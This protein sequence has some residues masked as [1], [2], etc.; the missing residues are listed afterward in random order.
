M[1]NKQ[2]NNHIMRI[3]FYLLFILIFSTSLK[4]QAGLRNT[5]HGLLVTNGPDVMITINEQY[6]HAEY[7]NATISS[8]TDGSIFQLRY[9]AFLDE[10]E[11]ENAGKRY[12]LNKIE[13]EEI[14]FT[15][16]NKKYV[17]LTYEFD[18]NQITG[19]LAEIYKSS[20]LSVYKKEKVDI[21]EGNKTH[22]A[23]TRDYN[24]YKKLKP[25]YFIEKGKTL[26]EMPNSKKKVAAIFGENSGKIAAFIDENKISLN[27]DMELRKLFEFINSMN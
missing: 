15:E 21:F 3:L 13:G 17:C 6:F 1:Q 14:F 25:V 10:I 18:K 7:E 8:Q 23:S 5:V 19:F 11:Y 4:S 22:I 16:L 24:E 2:Q 12:F 9:N 20:N 26:V 27:D